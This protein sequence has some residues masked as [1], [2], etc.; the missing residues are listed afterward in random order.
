[1]SSVAV[2]KGRLYERRTDI[3]RLCGREEWTNFRP[4][5][6]SANQ[7]IGGNR[8]A[9]GE[10]QL[11][12]SVIKAT[13][14]REPV[15]PSYGVRGQRLNQKPAKVASGDLRLRCFAPSRLV[16]KNIS[17]PIDYPLGI[18]ARK[19]EIEEFIVEARGPQPELTVVF[20]NIQQAALPPRIWRRFRFVDR[21]LD[22]VYVQNSCER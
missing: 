19:N 22:S 13:S 21:R 15:A 9:V 3:R 16:E 5:T 4:R 8:R 14:F 10:K 11:V 7:E 1:M 18:L 6:V 20:V 2:E 17:A 12:L